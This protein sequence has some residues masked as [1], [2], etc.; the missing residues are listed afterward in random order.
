MSSTT[1]VLSSNWTVDDVLRCIPTSLDVLRAFGV[2][3]C[4]GRPDTL[5]IAARQAS[6]EV[7]ELVD[8]LN[9]CARAYLP[10][11]VSGAAQSRRAVSDTSCSCCSSSR[12]DKTDAASCQP[13]RRTAD[14]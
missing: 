4:C 10:L 5:T 14:R 3:T 11:E 6:V 13:G 1:T 2:D 12:D 9:V 8:A 7:D